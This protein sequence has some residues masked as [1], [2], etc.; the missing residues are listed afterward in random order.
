M[1]TI[2]RSKLLIWSLALGGIFAAGCSVDGSIID[3]TKRSTKITSSQLTGISAGSAH[4]VTTDSGYTVSSSV[5]SP[6]GGEIVTET[7]NGYKVYSS[8]Q[9]NIN[10]ETSQTIVE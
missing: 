9:G 3:T 5:G 2:G 6:Y 7:A 10:A 4:T 8:L 1:A